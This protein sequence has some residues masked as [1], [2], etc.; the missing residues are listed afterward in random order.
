MANYCW[1]ISAV[2]LTGVTTT[3]LAYEAFQGPTEL[4]HYDPARAYE[5]YTL[6]TPMLGRNTYLLDMSGQV[7]NT[8]PLPESW[9]DPAVREH[10]RLLEDGTLLRAATSGNGSTPGT[11]QIVDWDGEVIWEYENTR[12]G[13]SGHGDFRMIWN[14]KLEERTLM[15][16]T[17]RVITHAEAIA[18]GV[19]PA[20]RESYASRPDGLVE[21]DMDGNVIW[22]WNISD[23]LVQDLNHNLST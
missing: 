17:S 14:P 19:D 7:I 18:L 20:L 4:I 16:I 15:Y 3:T 2:T 23:H 22:E 13:Y 12:A 11:Y 6:F 1:L 21:V 10:A 8:W 9:R 5:G